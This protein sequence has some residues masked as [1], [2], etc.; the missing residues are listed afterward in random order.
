MRCALLQRADY[1]DAD[2]ELAFGDESLV[3]G[4]DQWLIAHGMEF[5]GEVYNL[6]GGWNGEVYHRVRRLL[7]ASRAGIDIAV[8]ERPMPDLQ[9]LLRGRAD[10]SGWTFT[11]P[12]WEAISSL[13]LG[14]KVVDPFVATNDV[15]LGDSHS[16]AVSYPGAECKRNDGLTMHGLLSRGLILEQECNTLTICAGNIDV[17]HHFG[18]DQKDVR[19]FAKDL[20]DVLYMQVT[21]AYNA[22]HIDDFKIVS[23]YP[24]EWEGR[25]V[26]KTGW[27]KGEPF[28]MPREARA[29]CVAAWNE[30]LVGHFG[31]RRVV[32]WPR[33]WYSIH[34][35]VYA[36]TY[37]EKPGSVHLSPEYHH[38]D[39]EKNQ[40]NRKLTD[41]FVKS[42]GVA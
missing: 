37:M 25:R 27:F 40:I 34:P 23:L 26:P 17:R 31:S 42:I 30:L 15:V 14:M 8:L 32:T 22:H 12:E 10:K 5:D 41:E 18:R 7:D 3:F 1:K 24:V 9:K 20:I 16:V 35:Q 39:Y 36:N 6:F 2:I 21:Q 38:W 11:D 19:Q 28:H 29:E 13:C 33:T 4:A